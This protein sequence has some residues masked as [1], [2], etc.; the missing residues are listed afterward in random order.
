MA[1]NVQGIEVAVHRRYGEIRVLRSIHA[2]DAGVVVNPLQCRGQIEGGVA[3]ALGAA[4]YEKLEVDVNGRISNPTFRNYH[5]PTFADTPLTEVHFADT[6]DRVGP[7]GAKSMSE[8]PFNPV[9]AA[10]AN[11]IRDASGIRLHETPFRADKLFRALVERDAS[12]AGDAK[13]SI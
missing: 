13:S 2:A 9:A 8:S 10:L 3:H 6:Y 4:L 7:L 5:I 11:A 12:R 1:F